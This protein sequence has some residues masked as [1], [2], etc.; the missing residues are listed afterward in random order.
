[1]T[2]RRRWFL[3][4]LAAA[5]GCVLPAIRE[6]TL[7]SRYNL[8][9]EQLVIHSDFP[10]P[11]NHRLLEELTARRGDLAEQLALPRVDEPVHIYLFQD[12]DRFKTFLSLYHPDF[13]QR[14]AFFLETD[15]RLEVY[16]QWGD[17]VA[18]DLRHEVCHGYL[19]AVVPGVPLW[20]DE[21]LAEYSEAPRGHHGIHRSHLANLKRRIEKENW[22]PNLPR[23]DHFAPNRDMSQDEYAEAWA[24][25]H[26][27][28]KTRPELLSL[29]RT[30]LAELRRN[31]AAEGLSPRMH[32]MLE[33][34]DLEVN[35]HVRRLIQ[36][37]A[38]QQL[39]DPASADTASAEGRH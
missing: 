3:L 13:P 12:S 20:L 14:R 19:H 31:G 16:A 22:Q 39:P 25:T 27:L 15:T 35:A 4:G 18:E 8:V 37:N 33:R 21:G 38:W 10:L 6:L 5:G 32:R 26:F 36:Q 34:P 30:Y 24:W 29:V 1:M 7:P 23:L 2:M 28:L 17:Y 11:P 9:R